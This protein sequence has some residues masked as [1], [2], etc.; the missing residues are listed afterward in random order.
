MRHQ[1]P[2][3]PKPQ[4]MPNL[5]AQAINLKTTQEHGTSR[6]DTMQSVACAEA[7]DCVLSASRESRVKV[8]I[9]KSNAERRTYN[10]V[11]N[12]EHETFVHAQGQKW[13]MDSF[14]KYYTS[15][16][17]PLGKGQPLCRTPQI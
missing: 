1:P 14:T 9:W 13:E 2:N 12:E 5:N 6:S 17:G 15:P 11:K 10:K 7:L 8:E 3:F 4:N 16:A